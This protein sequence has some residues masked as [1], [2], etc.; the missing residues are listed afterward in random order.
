MAEL[1]AVAREAKLLKRFILGDMGVSPSLYSRLK[2]SGGVRVNGQLARGNRLLQPG[3]TVTL[4][5]HERPAYQPRPC[6]Q[7]V[8]VLYEDEHLFIV[9]KP[10][11]MAC[12]SSLTKSHNALENCLYARLGCPQDFVFR[13]VNRLDAGTSGLM[14]VARTAHSHHQLQGLLHSPAFTREYWALTQGLPHPAAGIVDLPIGQG[15]GVRRLVDPLGKPSRTHYKTL[16][17]GQGIALVHFQL[18]TGRTHQI[19]V[20]M[21]HLGH[22]LVGDWLYGQG[23]ARLPGRFALHCFRLTL[24]HPATG[25]T[26]RFAAPP[27]PE[28]SAL[29][30]G[31][32]PGQIL[33]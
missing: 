29:V 5:L 11:P 10:A 22:P 2:F 30:P 31:L 15:E 19:R 14:V 32:L 33:L 18:D 13:P 9:N 28:L 25:E 8:P 3:D 7:K 6:Q 23:D 27:P 26:L 20:H 4:S 12:H 21:A 17:Q 24:C 16:A 1:V